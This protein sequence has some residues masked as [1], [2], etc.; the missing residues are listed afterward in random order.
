MESA[1]AR[2][3]A[4]VSRRRR[5]VVAAWLALLVAGGW[6]TLHQNDQLSGG[7]W[8]VPG[9]PSMRLAGMLD[10]FP[11]TTPPAFTVLVT[12]PNGPRAQ[13]QRARRLVEG[14]PDVRAGLPV[15]LDGGTAA[16]L[17]SPPR[18]ASRP[19]RSST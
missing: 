16:F 18:N 10:D 12:N 6:F 7:G 9:S 13:L 3:A 17:P 15:I 4:L 14:E 5:A 11:G 8:E 1:L 19:S 2:L